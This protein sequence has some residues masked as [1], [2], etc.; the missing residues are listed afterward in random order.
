MAVRRWRSAVC[1]KTRAG[2][3]SR[4]RHFSSMC[5][6][7]AVA[8]GR[9]Q[10]RRSFC[11]PYCV[12]VVAAWHRFRCGPGWSMAWA[13]RPGGSNGWDLRRSAPFPQ[14]RSQQSKHSY[15]AVTRQPEAQGGS[16]HTWA[17]DASQRHHA[18]FWCVL[19]C[20]RGW[21]GWSGLGGGCH[22]PAKMPCPWVHATNPGEHWHFCLSLSVSLCLAV[23]VPCSGVTSEQE[24]LQRK[25]GEEAWP[26]RSVRDPAEWS[27][28]FRSS[29]GCRQKQPRVGCCRTLCTDYPEAKPDVS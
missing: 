9:V 22:Q 24:L 3:V 4:P 15:E 5:D 12:A 17:H 18:A 10:K 14:V 21:W 23:F 16:G 29:P 8:A 13:L 1:R 25:C 6:P 28:S 27:L 20:W 2:C 7:S 11:G 26:R 19:C